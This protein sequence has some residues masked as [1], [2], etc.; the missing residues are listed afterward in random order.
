MSDIRVLLIERKLCAILSILCLYYNI[1]G[2]NKTKIVNIRKGVKFMKKKILSLVLSI[3]AVLTLGV[4]T[5]LATVTVDCS[6]CGYNFASAWCNGDK[7]DYTDKHYPDGLECIR[8][9]TAH[10]VS[11]IC[12]SCGRSSTT[13]S[14]HSIKIN[15]SSTQCPYYPSQSGGP[16]Y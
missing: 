1:L 13:W 16:C 6:Y 4:Q 7:A 10:Y 5:C 12:I 8:S 2:P 9:H 15:H 14:R 11:F 3:M